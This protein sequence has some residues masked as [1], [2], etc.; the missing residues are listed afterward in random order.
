M[1]VDWIETG[2]SKLA[3]RQLGEGPDV[4][5]VH[6]WPLHGLTWRH[7]ARALADRYRCHLFDLPGAGASVWSRQ[8]PFGIAAHASALQKAIDALGLERFALV[9]HDSGAAVS[10][11]VAA[12]AGARVWG[13]VV[14]G[15][16]IPGHRPWLVVLM[17]MMGLLP[18]QRVGARTLLGTRW[19][20]RS[21]LVFGACFHDVDRAEGEFQELF[22]EPLLRSDR[23]LAGQMRLP[24]AWRWAEVDALAERH[25][26]IV[27]PTLLLWGEGDPY[28]PAHKA[29]AMAPQFAGG[30]TFR[31]WPDARLFPHEEHPERFAQEVGAFLAAHAPR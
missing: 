12:A 11:Y 6:G 27:A 16:E 18:G 28:F 9:G 7:T 1:D 31:S 21:R 14:S 20:R 10:R 2:E 29:R 13:N 22:V 19:L 8:T 17:L 23:A 24:A 3:H 26:Q 5:F 15:S 25:A 30:A 4:V